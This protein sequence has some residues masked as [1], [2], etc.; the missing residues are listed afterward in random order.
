[1]AKLAQLPCPL[2]GLLPAAGKAFWSQEGVH[3]PPH[4]HLNPPFPGTTVGKG[5]W[6]RP[7]RE[8]PSLSPSQWLI[9]HRAPPGLGTDRGSP[10]CACLA[11]RE[12]E[13]AAISLLLAAAGWC[14]PAAAR[15]RGSSEGRWMLHPAQ[16]LALT[17]AGEQAANTAQCRE[18]LQ[19]IQD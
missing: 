1:M 19:Q 13:A 11:E 14:P 8:R 3:G 5:R 17:I 9:S 6:A 10:P 16:Q 15:R 7:Q 18:L 12:R 4:T 2:S